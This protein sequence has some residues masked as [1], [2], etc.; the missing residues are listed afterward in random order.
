MAFQ[1]KIHSL[2]RQHVPGPLQL[3]VEQFVNF[4]VVPLTVFAAVL[5]DF[6]LGAR[7]QDFRVRLE[8]AGPAHFGPLLLQIHRLGVVV[9]GHKLPHED[10]VHLDGGIEVTK[11]QVEHQE[12]FHVGSDSVLSDYSDQ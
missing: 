12:L 10:V 11:V 3:F 8:M 2:N 4:P 6:A 5:G 1:S 7:F 9:V